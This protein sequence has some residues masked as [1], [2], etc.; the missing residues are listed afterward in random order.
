MKYAVKNWRSFQHYNDRNPPWIKLHF[1]L[2]S[3]ADWV[4]LADASRVLAVAIMLVAS[5]NEGIIDASAA[6]LAY[7][8]RVA[9]LNSDPDIKPL[10]ECGFLVDA[11]TMLA[12]AS[13]S[14]ANARP[15]TESK[16]VRKTESKKVETEEISASS[17][18][19][20]AT[21]GHRLPDDWKPSESDADFA[22]QKGFDPDAIAEIAAGFADYWRSLAGA[23]ARK[24][25]WSMTWKNWVRK[26]LERNGP[27]RAKPQGP[28]VSDTM[29]RLLEGV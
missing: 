6:G 14:L 27:R 10:I 26:E 3:S 18:R 25:D 24:V 17:R 7:I 19:R 12:D 23:K 2:L 13:K 11:S 16:K 4:V 21:L 1:A 20:T 8:K 22:R 5:R 9:Y 15:E 28:K 29:A